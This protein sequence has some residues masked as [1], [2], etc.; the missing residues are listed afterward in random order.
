MHDRPTSGPA[1]SGDQGRIGGVRRSDHV[2]GAGQHRPAMGRVARS[3][4]VLALVAGSL[5]SL[6]GSAAAQESTPVPLPPSSEVV[7][8]A[9][10]PGAEQVAPGIAGPAGAPPA[11]VPPAQVPPGQVPAE[12]VPPSQAP[13][14]QEPAPQVPIAPPDLL[15]GACFVLLAPPSVTVQPAPG[16]PAA[17]AGQSAPIGPAPVIDPFAPTVPA[18]PTGDVFVPPGQIPSQDTVAPAEE[19]VEHVE[20][21]A[22]VPNQ[23]L[24]V[25]LGP[26]PGACSV[27]LWPAAGATATHAPLPP[28]IEGGATAPGQALVA[29]SIEPTAP[30]TTAPVDDGVGGPPPPVQIPIP[31][32]PTPTA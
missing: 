9:P 4:L 14:A 12:R 11:Q 18:A 32:V 8:A 24:I 1:I 15:T 2:D 17:N 31:P 5:V 21:H 7:P 25:I 22:A 13:A 16:V 26:T 19:A 23:V 28:P 20:F 6:A 27:L 10:A 3:L 30:G 29:A